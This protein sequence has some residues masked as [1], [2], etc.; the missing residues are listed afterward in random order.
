MK[1]KY[2]IQTPLGIAKITDE[3][4]ISSA[5]LF[6]MKDSWLQLPVI[7]QVAF[8]QLDLS[9]KRHS[10]VLSWILRTTEFNKRYGVIRYSM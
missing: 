6:Q 3:N 8:T 4:G 5:F 9:G 10:L 2:H 7:L 1:W